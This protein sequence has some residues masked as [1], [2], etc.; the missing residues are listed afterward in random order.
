M[1]WKFKQN[2]FLLPIILKV[3][4]RDPFKIPILDFYAYC[5]EYCKTLPTFLFIILL[6]QG[7][8]VYKLKFRD[9]F[10]LFP[11]ILKVQ[12]LGHSLEI[13]RLEYLCLLF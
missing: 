4:K 2:F 5:F 12:K 11:L 1:K 3:Q 13:P 6:A 9:L 7:K 8:L 10:L